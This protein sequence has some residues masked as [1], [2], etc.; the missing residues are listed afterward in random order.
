[1]LEDKDE[2]LGQ[3]AKARIKKLLEQNQ[4]LEARLADTNG[5]AGKIEELSAQVEALGAQLAEAQTGAQSQMA[6][7]TKNHQIERALLAKGITGDEGI[8]FA[9]MVYE[10]IAEDERPDIGEWLSGE[11]PRGVSAY[12][13]QQVEPPA[14]AAP[15]APEPVA[16]PQTIAQPKANGAITRPVYEG[17]ADLKAAT[18]TTTNWKEHRSQFIDEFG[19]MKPV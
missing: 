13:P 3:G 17:R 4:E 7:L 2:D 8:N 6:Q 10:A 5:H 11:L 19:R 15:I 16:T 9:K 14:A 12:L 1:M 18:S